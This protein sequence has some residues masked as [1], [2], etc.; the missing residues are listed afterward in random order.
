[1]ATG[2]RIGRGRQIPLKTDHLPLGFSIDRRY[3]RKE[4]LGIGVFSMIQDLFYCSPLDNAPQ[5]H[6]RH[7]VGQELDHGD[8][9]S[10][11]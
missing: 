9:V 8:I 7:I 11:E 3:G 5:I 1:M 6:H 10:D 4:R 2:R